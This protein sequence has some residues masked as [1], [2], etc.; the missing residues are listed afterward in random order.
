MKEILEIVAFHHNRPIS[1]D[2]T[3]PHFMGKPELV[4]QLCDLLAQHKLDIRFGV[5]VRADSVAKHP[6]IVRKM[7]AVGIEGFEMG[8]ESPNQEDI[9]STSKGMST[10]VH[11]TAV[12]NIKSWGG[13]AGGTFVIGLPDQTEEQILKFPEYAKKI[14]LTSTAYGIATPFPGTRFYEDLDAQGLIFEK[15]WNRYDEMHSI[16]HAKHIS[17][18]RTEELASICMAKFWTVD[19]FIEKERM[20][21]I[22]SAGKRPLVKFIGD[23]MQELNI[24]LQMGSQLQKKNL[25]KHVISVIEASAD[26]GV[27]KYTK[28]F[29]VHNIINMALL[30]KLL[31]DQIVQLTVTSKGEA[32]TSWILKTKGN[33]VEYIQVIPGRSDRST[34]NMDLDLDDFNFSESGSVTLVKSVGIVGKML[35]SNRGLR[36]QP[37]MIRLMIAGGLEMVV[38][39]L[40][41]SD[42]KARGKRSALSVESQ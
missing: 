23:K 41:D 32:I 19:M 38:G 14:G 35:A 6:E 21:T 2:V 27:E 34:I 15:D 17:S 13:N 22:R 20:L 29:R 11:V 28:E 25:G 4:E 5:K 1:I 30:L 12:N 10:D 39:H 36:K 16:F 33:G 18:E 42:R 3:D 40:R 24:S 9:I 8:I 31:G 37:T 26:P 7:I